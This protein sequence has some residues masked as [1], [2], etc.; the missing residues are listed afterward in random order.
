MNSSKKKVEKK[1]DKSSAVSLF[2]FKPTSEFKP[3]SIYHLI[4]NTKE[5]ELAVR[6]FPSQLL[7]IAVK[8][9]GL[10]D[11]TELIE[12]MSDA[13]LKALLA[14][15]L[16][17]KERFNVSKIWQWLS[18]PEASGDL[19]ILQKILRV[20]DLKIISLLIAKYTE[21]LYYDEPTDAPPAEGF[22]TPDK[23]RTWIRVNTSSAENDFYL[24]RLLA[25]LHETS[26]N[27]Y[28]Q[29][30]MVPQVAT[31]S[32]IE[33][34]ALKER[35]RVLSEIG[36][37]DEELSKELNTPLPLERFLRENKEFLTASQKEIDLLNLK[38]K[39]ATL[40]AFKGGSATP[41]S[42]LREMVR[43][44][45]DIYEEQTLLVNAALLY[46]GEELWDYKNIL[47]TFKSVTGLI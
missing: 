40:E 20:L 28:Y 5:P 36:F 47:K 39:D 15:D 21:V 45:E 33:E 46:T 13:Q 35:N 31:F 29:L 1:G 27:V 34:E 12:I 41:L 10:V 24:S 43:N 14:M 22:I 7:Y 44:L 42:L 38:K 2:S 26:S 30:L 9:R 23:G 16:W 6:Q 11:S 19:K 18:L 4:F 37:P 25:L 32:M 8:E 17:E 3:S